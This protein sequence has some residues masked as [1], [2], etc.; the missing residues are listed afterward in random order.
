[1]GALSITG[2]TEIKTPFE[3]L[4]PGTFHV[5]ATILFRSGLTPEQLA[6]ERAGAIEEAILRE[7]P[8]TVAM[9]ILEPVQ[10][11]GGCIPPPADYFRRV[12]E[13]C[14]RYGVLYAS[15]EV[16]CGFGRLGYMFGAQRFGVQPDIITCAKGLTSG[17]SPLGACIISDRLAEPFLGEGPSFLHGITFGGHPVS[18][19]VAMANLD[20]IEGEGLLERVRQM[21]PLFK[22]T[23]ESLWDIPIVGDIRG[24]GAFWA[25]ELVKERE[26][27]GQLQRRGSRLPAPRPADPRTGQSRPDLPGRR[28]RRPGGAALPAAD[29][30]THPVRGDGRGDAPSLHAGRRRGGQSSRPAG[31]G[32]RR[33]DPAF[34]AGSAPCAA[35]RRC[36]PPAPR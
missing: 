4:V 12:R 32:A 19:A 36:A 30:G 2:L 28:P 18:C 14:D 1:M 7:G 15:D 31:P 24:A 20:I 3:P 6:V 27:N 16:I 13:I 21:E 34:S 33:P 9:V 10:N 23:L 25:V 11:A 5:P 26:T 35:R 17:Y 22:A 8:E 29:H